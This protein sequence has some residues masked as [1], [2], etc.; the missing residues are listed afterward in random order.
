MT[1]SHTVV[2]GATGLVGR[3]VLRALA[4]RG[5]RVRAVVRTPV[6]LTDATEVRAL[7]DLSGR[8]AWAAALERI[9]TVIHLAARVHVMREDA[10][11]PLAAFRA[12]N[13]D[14]TRRLAEAAAQ[15]GVRR[16]VFVSSIKV[17]GERTTGRPFTPSDRPAPRDPYA[18]SKL[19]A[20]AALERMAKAG[21][22]ELVILRPPLVYGPGVRGNVRRLLRLVDS[23]M[24]LPFGLVR[25]KRSL[26][27][28]D[29]LV[30]AIV[31]SA[32]TDAATG[33]YLVCDG[34]AVSTPELVGAVARGL[35]R[36]VR[37]L[38]V[39][40]ALLRL[41]GT[42]AGRG[43]EVGRLLDSLEIDD[44]ATRRGLGWSPPST[45]EDGMARLTAWYRGLQTMR[46]G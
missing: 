32:S 31:R 4:G 2:T 19:E 27:S 12:V 39:P 3:A 24:P 46:D 8:V 17:N 40:P 18:Q 21:A 28:L 45:F 23:G 11:D 25:N 10:P 41:A 14:A 36:P 30:S 1:L 42:V 34:G 26:V 33:I 6:D 16:F 37:L 43:A 5:A 22:F 13:V 35:D 15:A 29:N 44:S 20:E 38:P 9:D 7:G